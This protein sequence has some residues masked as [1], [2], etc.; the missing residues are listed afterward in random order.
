[1]TRQNIQRIA[2]VLLIVGIFFYVFPDKLEAVKNFLINVIS[3]AKKTEQDPL[4]TLEK[5]VPSILQPTGKL[6]E[7]FSFGSQYTDLQRENAETEIKGQ[8]VNWRLP[9]YEIIKDGDTYIVTTER[10]TNMVTAMLG[11]NF[12]STTIQLT[13]R[14]DAERQA[15]GNLKTNDLIEIKGIISGSSMRNLVISPEIL[16]SQQQ[17]EAAVNNT[18]KGQVTPLPVVQETALP[19]DTQAANAN[20]KTRFGTLAVRKDEKNPQ[21]KYIVMLPNQRLLEDENDYLSIDQVYQVGDADVVLLSSNCGGSGCGTPGVAFLTLKANGVHTLT[22]WGVSQRGEPKPIQSGNKLILDL[23]WNE[24]VQQVMEYENGVATLKKR[25]PET[26]EMGDIE[27]CR[28]LYQE[29]YVAHIER[30]QCNEVPG[31]IGGMSTWRTYLSMSNDPRFNLE[32]F[33]K[34]AR[35][36]CQ[37]KTAISYNVFQQQICKK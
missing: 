23:G 7:I 20:I 15:I 22:Q 30:G 10:S 32:E 21:K 6:A 16:W 31:E 17:Q 9:V 2:P 1:M 35:E 12:V 13:A 27:N 8:V 33:E 4:V 26:G 19:S 11:M 5:T 36:G 25:K 24:G 18:T 37:K 34:I 29:L 3:V 28:W 14:N